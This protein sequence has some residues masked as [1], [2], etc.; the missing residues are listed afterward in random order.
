MVA[1]AVTWP[2]AGEEVQHISRTA[3]QPFCSRAQR[4]GELVAKHVGSKHMPTH[5]GQPLHIQ[6]ML[7]RHSGPLANRRAAQPKRQRHG[8]HASTSVGGLPDQFLVH[9]QSLAFLD[10]VGQEY[11]DLRVKS[12][13]NTRA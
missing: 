5:P 3:R 12:L 1:C 6:H 2:P 9:A 13:G 7:W 10:L 11:L 8:H 4:L